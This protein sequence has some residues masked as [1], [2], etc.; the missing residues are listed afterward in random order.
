M[1]DLLDRVAYF[2]VRALIFLFERIPLA[3]GLR[4]GDFLGRCVFY[5]SNKRRVAYI[6]LKA[7]LGS[8][9]TP[10]ECWKTVRDHF[11]FMGQS[12]V[13][14]MSFKRMERKHHDLNLKV[15]GLERYEALLRSGHGGVLITAHFGNW[16]LLQVWSGLRGTP[17][18]VLT[19]EQKYPRLNGLINELRESH[20]SVSISRGATSP[21]VRSRGS[22]CRSW[23]GGRRSRQGLSN[24]LTVRTRSLCRFLS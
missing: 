19:R 9:L 13:E 18:H 17:I 11:G 15:H 4:I 24:W 3:V 10:A 5:V 1:E 7:A 21:P 16:E 14:V 6:N 23:A 8:Q 20:G 2:V 22:S 12:V